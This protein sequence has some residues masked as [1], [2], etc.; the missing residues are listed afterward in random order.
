MSFA[1]FIVQSWRLTLY[2]P[3]DI[4]CTETRELDSFAAKTA[5]EKTA[6]ERNVLIIVVC[7]SARPSSKYCPN[8]WAQSSAGVDWRADF[9]SPGTK[10]SRHKKPMRCLRAAASPRQG[11]RCRARDR[12]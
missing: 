9:F 8:S 5:F 10:P 4:A 6:D 12:R 7:A 1:R 2:K 11:H 3:G